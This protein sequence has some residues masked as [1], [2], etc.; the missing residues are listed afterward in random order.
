MAAVIRGGKVLPHV[1][2]F[3]DAVAMAT[4]GESF[5][6]Y[7]GHDPTTDRAI[8]IFVPVESDVLGNAITTFAIDNL[9]QFGIDY[10]IYRQRIYNPEVIRSWRAMADRGNI[11]QNHFDHVHI[12][13]EAT[14]LATFSTFKEDDMTDEETKMLRA[15]YV[16]MM[17][18][19][20]G[21]GKALDDLNREVISLK[22]SVAKIN[23]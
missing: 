15:V 10:I 1:Q 18:P 2:A 11:T 20:F 17:D 7:P 16:Q 13:F 21:V 14:A 22:E 6:T 23:A 12:S 3:A 19:R 8:D 5:G 9:E 4:G